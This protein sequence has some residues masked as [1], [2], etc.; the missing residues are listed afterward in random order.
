MTRVGRVEQLELHS[1]L[2][3]VI[4]YH[5]KFIRFTYFDKPISAFNDDSN[6][7]TN[8]PNYEILSPRKSDA[9]ERNT[10]FEPPYFQTSSMHL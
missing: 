9:I 2:N 6:I 5:L 1:V 7:T 8:S 3:A 4:Q 10:A